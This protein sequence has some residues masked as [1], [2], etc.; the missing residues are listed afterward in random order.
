MFIYELAGVFLIINFCKQIVS[1]S[2]V[3]SFCSEICRY[4]DT[5][6][7]VG[8][9]DNPWLIFSKYIDAVNE[10]CVQDMLPKGENK[11]CD[12]REV[13]PILCFAMS[14]AGWIDPNAQALLQNS[15]FVYNNISLIFLFYLHNL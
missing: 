14:Q 9:L 4:S 6:K 1:Y 10:K 7:Q 12:E 5:A 15:T 2:Q 3:E 8:S 13:M 11:L